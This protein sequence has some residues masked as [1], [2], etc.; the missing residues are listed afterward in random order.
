MAAKKN[1]GR[2]ADAS[3]GAAA[4]KKKSSAKAT[5]G[6]GSVVYDSTRSKLRSYDVDAPVGNRLGSR[7]M[8]SSESVKN[9]RVSSTARFYEVDVP[10]YGT[11]KT[12]DAVVKPRAKKAAKVTRRYSK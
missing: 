11:R 8:G 9:N 12:S 6:K 7:R 4:A 3:A 5:K 1:T 10:D 2:S